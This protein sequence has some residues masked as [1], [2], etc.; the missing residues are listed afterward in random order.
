MN[1]SDDIPTLV[2]DLLM[3]ER[4]GGYAKGAETRETI[5]RTALSILIEEGYPAM[6][7]RRV[8]LASGIKF[9]NLT[10]H[11]RSREDLV[12]ELFDAVIRSYEVE[13]VAIAQMPGAAPEDR[14]RRVCLLILDDIRTKKT[15]HFFPEIWAL[16]NHDSFVF[17][18]MQELYVRARAPILD[19][20]A[21]M[22]KDLLPEEQ[23]VLAL[24]ISASMEGTTMFAGHEKPFEP[25]M[26]EIEA[27]AVESFIHL[28]R[29]WKR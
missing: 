4:E 27:I 3:P 15:T 29:N 7:M 23:E 12:R 26:K 14:L 5:L 6:S 19:I 1:Q 13:F 20:I 22:R 10:Y 9:G 17:E 24:F 11:F 2:T 16:S 28:V 18:R 8:A 21:E 25:R